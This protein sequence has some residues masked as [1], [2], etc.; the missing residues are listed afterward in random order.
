MPHKLRQR[1]PSWVVERDEDVGVLDRDVPP[2]AVRVIED[3][4]VM[5][6]DAFEDRALLVIRNGLPAGSPGQAVDFV[7]R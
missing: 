3:P 2:R 6:A 4:C 1:D 7:K 5:S